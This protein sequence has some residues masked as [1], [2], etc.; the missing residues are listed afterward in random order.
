MKVRL[1]TI[2]DAVA[3]VFM[4]PFVSRSEIDAV[5]QI[6]A[7]KNDP[8][9]ASTPIMSKPHEFSLYEI[10]VLDDESGYITTISPPRHV[11]SIGDLWAVSP[12]AA[13][14]STVPT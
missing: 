12:V 10:G 5:R 4:S 1:Y 2:Y 6:V 14:L 13:P 11:A 9:I 3:G 8:A 7:S